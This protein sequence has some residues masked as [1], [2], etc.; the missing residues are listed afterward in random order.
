MA[1]SRNKQGC[2]SLTIK[3]EHTCAH[4]FCST[5]IADIVA[6]TATRA[7]YCFMLVYS[8]LGCKSSYT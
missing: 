1:I 4:T 5:D 6:N 7:M 2:I 8:L 3:L